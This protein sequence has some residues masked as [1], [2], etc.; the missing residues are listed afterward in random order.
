MQKPIPR[1]EHPE[2]DGKTFFLNGNQ[3][4][5]LLIHGFTATTVEVRM[6]ADF[7]S[8]KG[9]TVSAPL[10]PGH[11]TTPEDLN[12]RKYGEWIKCVEDSYHLLMKTCTKVIIGGESMGAVL[13]LHLAESHP[14]INA[15]LLYSPAIKITSLKYSKIFRYF[16]PIIRKKDYHEITPWQGYSVYPLFA[17]SELFQLQKLVFKNL[18]KVQQPMV[19]FHGAYDRTIDLD[20]SDL[21]LSSAS[22]SIKTKHIN[23]KSGHLILLDKEFSDTADLTWKFLKELK[24]V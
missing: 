2:L 4:G 8:K 22:S 1:F 3:I 5:V 14:E 21:I 15:L 24:I 13:S 17:A 12:K 11:G 20:S 6:L 19:V 18:H 23:S 7:F 16:I 10:L 9:F